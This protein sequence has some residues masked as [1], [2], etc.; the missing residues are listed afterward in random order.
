[1]P[2]TT[3]M[4]T[5]FFSIISKLQEKGREVTLVWVPAHVGIPGNEQADALVKAATTKDATECWIPSI[6]KDVKRLINQNVLY[7]WQM[8]KH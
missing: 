1:M 5:E 7:Q 3:P 6:I 4:F 2:I 8:G